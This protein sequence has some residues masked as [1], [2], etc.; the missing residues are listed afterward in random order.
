MPEFRETCWEGHQ[1]FDL[2]LEANVVR[3]A[4]LSDTHGQHQRV[5]HFLEAPNIRE[6]AAQRDPCCEQDLPLESAK[7][8][9]DLL[10]SA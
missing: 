5:V 1:H 4:L 10:E 8:R 9:W 3:L 6:H 7:P 2:A